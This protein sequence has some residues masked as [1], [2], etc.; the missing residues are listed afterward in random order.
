MTCG[1]GPVHGQH[2]PLIYLTRV[3]RRRATASTAVHA[4]EPDKTARGDASGR[5]IAR[6]H[7]TNPMINKAQAWSAIYQGQID[8]SNKI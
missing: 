5:L 7:P 2:R 8:P 4:L 1:H 6:P 3:G